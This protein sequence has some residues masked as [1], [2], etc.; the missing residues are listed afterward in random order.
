MPFYCCVNIPNRFAFV[1]VALSAK[2]T[3]CLFTYFSGLIHQRDTNVS[4][5]QQYAVMLL[6][7][8]VGDK[9]Q[10]NKSLFVQLTK[11]IKSLELCIIDE[12]NYVAWCVL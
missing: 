7:H 12:W 8:K 2:R 5:R 4:N 9:G 11:F 1:R 10:I 3:V 6:S